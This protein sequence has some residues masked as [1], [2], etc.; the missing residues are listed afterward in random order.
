MDDMSW[1]NIP[2]SSNNNWSAFKKTNFSGGGTTTLH[3]IIDKLKNMI[4]YPQISVFLKD[5]IS[6]I[7]AK[8]HWDMTDLSGQTV[9]QFV[10]SLQHKSECHVD[11]L[12]L[13]L[14]LIMIPIQL[15]LILKNQI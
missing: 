3:D 5:F 7:V 6:I 13:R 8:F 2:E 12:H 4:E 11:L 15:N 14:R 9:F 1:M 10:N